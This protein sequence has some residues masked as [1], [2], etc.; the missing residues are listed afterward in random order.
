MSKADGKPT[1]KMLSYASALAHNLEEDC[2]WWGRCDTLPGTGIH[3]PIEP[4]F[5]EVSDYIGDAKKRWES[6][7]EYERQ[8][9]ENELENELAGYAEAACIDARRDW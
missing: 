5:Q 7:P 1:E 3:V 4:S 6:S 8:R 9:E 2:P